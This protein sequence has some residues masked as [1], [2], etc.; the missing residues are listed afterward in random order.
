MLLHNL[1]GAM[2][3]LH[4]NKHYMESRPYGE[5]I[6]GGGILIGLLAAG[7]STS[8]LYRR[9]VADYGVRWTAA[10]GVEGR[11]KSP[12][13][14][15]DTLYMVHRVDDVRASGTRPGQAIMTVGMSGENQHGDTCC[16]GVFE[17]HVRPPGSGV[18]R[19]SPS[20]EAEAAPRPTPRLGQGAPHEGTGCGAGSGRPDGRGGSHLKDRGT[21]R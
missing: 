9:L 13:Y 20:V 15:G 7:W 12:F 8:D 10:L 1:M 14:P 4:A 11:F 16:V 6:L 3:P 18:G 21:G 2:S 17:R 5:R 19:L